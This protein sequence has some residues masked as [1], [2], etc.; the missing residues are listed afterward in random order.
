MSATPAAKAI[1]YAP[2]KA[3]QLAVILTHKQLTLPKSPEAISRLGSAEDY[4]EGT[5]SLHTVPI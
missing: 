4:L 3:E 2:G 1:R 5:S